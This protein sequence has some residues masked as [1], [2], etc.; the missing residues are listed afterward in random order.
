MTTTT[1]STRSYKQMSIRF[2]VMGGLALVV[3]CG[4]AAGLSDGGQ[5][6]DSGGIG[7]SGIV[8]D[9]VSPG[10]CTDGTACFACLRL[11]NAIRVNDCVSVSAGER[12]R[13]QCLA[14]NGTASCYDAQREA[15]NILTCQF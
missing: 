9:D 1:I 8:S 15:L 11:A 6:I 5:L 10:V 12:L 7:D 4:N 2:I 14:T 13:V 3:A